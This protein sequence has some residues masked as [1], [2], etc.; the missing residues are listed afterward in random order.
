M[1]REGLTKGASIVLTAAVTAWISAAGCAG[2]QSKKGLNYGDSARAA[3]EEAYED[4]EDDNCLEAE[5]AFREVRR[6]YPY[7]RYAAL[8]ELR[9]SDCLFQ[10]GKYQEAVQAYRQFVRFRPSHP[11]VPYARF[12]V[13]ESYF[14]QIPEDWLLSPPSYER[15]QGSTREA[16]RQIRK[17]LLDYPED[18]HVPEARDMAVDALT[19]LARHELYAAEFYLSHDQPKAA[20]MRLETLLNAYA[21]SA[22]EPEAL[23]LLGRTHL[24]LRQRAQALE[25]FQAI[26]ERFPKSG[27]AKEARAYLDE[28]T[29]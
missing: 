20:I 28:L 27:Y 4:F 21:G 1:A 6:E 10:D 18:K 12:K 3:Y 23:L 26:I 17:F 25:A 7:S 2:D 13:A 16:L 8:A 19:L 9:V 29:G 22:V 15:D 24:N 14:K 11:E 5:P